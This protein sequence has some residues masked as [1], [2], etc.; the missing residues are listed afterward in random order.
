MSSDLAERI[1]R[2]ASAAIDHEQPMIDA[3]PKAL[4]GVVIELTFAGGG[5][6]DARCYVEHHFTMKD[7]AA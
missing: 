1:K 5:V 3:Y 6:R 4:R 7:R 2:A